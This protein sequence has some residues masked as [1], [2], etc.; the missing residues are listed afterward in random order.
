MRTLIELFETST[1][2]FPNNPLLW[3]KPKDRYISSTYLEIRQQV[4]AFGAGLMALGFQ[5]EERIGLLS[6]GRNSWLVSELGIFY[7]GGVNVPLSVKLEAAE[8][9]NGDC[10]G[11]AS[12]KDQRS[13]QRSS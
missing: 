5:K 6:E 11:R 13:Y 2:K 8:L 4:Y 3:E 10:F 9:K 1:A 7:C 12:F